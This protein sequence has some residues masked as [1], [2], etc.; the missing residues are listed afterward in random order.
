MT[1][2]IRVFGNADDKAKVPELSKVQKG[3]WD[4]FLQK[5]AIPGDRKNTGLEALLRETFPIKSFDIKLFFSEMRMDF[6][7]FLAFTI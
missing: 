6:T 3:S 5:D 1:T 7:T 2:E 4:E